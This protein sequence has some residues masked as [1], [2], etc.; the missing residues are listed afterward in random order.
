MGSPLCHCSL[1]V[2]LSEGTICSAQPLQPSRQEW[3]G[4]G[5]LTALLLAWA[6]KRQG[7]RILMARAW[8]G[9]LSGGWGLGATQALLR[10]TW[11]AL[12]GLGH[13]AKPHLRAGGWSPTLKPPAGSSLVLSQNAKPL[14]LST[15]W[16]LL[17]LSAEACCW[18][19]ESN[20]ESP[21]LP[22]LGFQRSFVGRKI[23]PKPRLNLLHS[24]KT[25]RNRGLKFP[26]QSGSTPQLAWLL[27]SLSSP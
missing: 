15:Q 9:H 16:P 21:F 8:A 19:P 13:C 2:N 27:S 3:W 12:P 26:C 7:N 14:P 10:G 5:F 18:Q 1:P 25:K 20:P 6:T 11:L 4:R 17:F 24:Q 23:P 22:T